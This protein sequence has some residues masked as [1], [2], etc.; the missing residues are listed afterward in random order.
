RSNTRWWNGASPAGAASTDAAT[1]WLRLAM[2]R[3][4]S[5][6][7]RPIDWSIA[8]GPRRFRKQHLVPNEVLRHCAQYSREW[9]DDRAIIQRLMRSRTDEPDRS[10]TSQRNALRAA[11]PAYLAC[12][13]SSSSIRRSWL[14]FAVRSERASDPV[15]ICP[16][17]VATARSAMVESSVSPERCDI[18]AA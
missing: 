17:L 13:P 15:L 1:N 6:V 4:R 7:L 16:Q 12:G 14:Y 3:W 9:G 11:L 2:A 5:R 18:T 10:L 8:D